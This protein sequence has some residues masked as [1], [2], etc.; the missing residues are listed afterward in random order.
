M[1]IGRHVEKDAACVAHANH[2]GRRHADNEPRPLFITL[3]FLAEEVARV[4]PNDRSIGNA[5]LLR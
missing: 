2:H 3:V 1:E 5:W 4:S